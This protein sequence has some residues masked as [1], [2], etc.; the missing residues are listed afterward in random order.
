MIYQNNSFINKY[1]LLYINTHIPFDTIDS[2]GDIAQH[3]PPV[4]V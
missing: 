4:V 1:C 3:L 2:T